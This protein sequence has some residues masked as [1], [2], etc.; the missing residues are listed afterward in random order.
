MSGGSEVQQD[1]LLDPLREGLQ[2]K[3]RSRFEALGAQRCV[4][5]SQ[6]QLA[7]HRL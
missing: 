2:S 6:Q 3:L 7:A 4:D 1:G 5:L